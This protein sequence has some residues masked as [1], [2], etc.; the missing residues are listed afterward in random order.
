MTERL[1]DVALPRPAPAPDA[2][3]MDERLYDLVETRVRRL[4]EDNPVLATVFGI[5]TEDHRLGRREP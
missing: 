5:H 2:G 3:P 1:A 4:L